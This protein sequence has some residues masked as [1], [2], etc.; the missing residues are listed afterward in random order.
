[1]KVAGRSADN[2]SLQLQKSKISQQSVRRNKNPKADTTPLKKSVWTISF[3]IFTDYWES[4]ANE[5][6]AMNYL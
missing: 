2:N 5:L 1:M 6:S 4:S 3:C